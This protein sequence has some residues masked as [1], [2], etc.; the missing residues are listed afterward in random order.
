MRKKNG[1]GAFA[2]LSINKIKKLATST[3]KIY[4]DGLYSWEEYLI[5]KREFSDLIRLIQIY[6]EK[7]IRYLR[8][9]QRK[10]RPLLLEEAKKRDIHEIEHLSKGGPIAF[11]DHLVNNDRDLN[12]FHRQL[13]NIIAKY[14]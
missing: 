9:S 12:N 4:I 1:M 11:C 5:L 10:H 7:E 2:E 13:D 14:Y 3:N 6:S 8:L